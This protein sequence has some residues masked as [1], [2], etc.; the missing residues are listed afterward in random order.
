MPDR[1]AARRTAHACSSARVA[2][3]GVEEQTIA[4][5]G[6]PSP[7]SSGSLLRH[8]TATHPNHRRDWWV[9]LQTSRPPLAAFVTVEA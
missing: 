5:P 6:E 8:R 3:R 2:T 1:T 9:A 7:D 4:S